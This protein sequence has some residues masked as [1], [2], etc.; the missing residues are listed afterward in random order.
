MKRIFL[1]NNA[2]G[3]GNIYHY[4]DTT[5]GDIYQFYTEKEYESYEW[6]IGT[7]ASTRKG[8][9]VQ[10]NFGSDPNKIQVIPITF[11]GKN[12]CN[13]PDSF[14]ILESQIVVMPRDSSII[15]PA[16]YRGYNTD[17]PNNI[18]E[19]ELMRDLSR[20]HP[21]NRSFVFNL[22]G[23]PQTC[24]ATRADCEKNNSCGEVISGYNMA[25]DV[26]RPVYFSCLKSTTPYILCSDYFLH[27]KGN[28]I[29]IDWVEE[30]S[31]NGVVKNQR[32]RKFIGTKNI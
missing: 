19:I 14:D 16:K 30:T 17:E 32:I 4:S 26:K 13:C 11:K 6:Q 27:V 7:E 1:Y 3:L 20:L 10:V 23:F 2:N 25:I 28:Q 21:S 22:L 8:N 15:E 5:N 9:L 24:F 31:V 12:I 29:I 18:F